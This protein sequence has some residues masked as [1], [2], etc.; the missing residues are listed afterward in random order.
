MNVEVDGHKMR[1]IRLLRLMEREELEARSGV[2]RSTVARI[3]LGRP[4]ARLSTVKKLAS[5]LQVDPAAL[6]EGEVLLRQR[7][8]LN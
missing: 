4:T 5:A 7:L 6:V 8:V 1:E 2:H 3:E